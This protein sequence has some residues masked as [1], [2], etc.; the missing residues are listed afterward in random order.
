MSTAV[1]H[2]IG[3]GVSEKAELSSEARAALNSADVVIGSDRQLATVSL[4]DGV[5]THVLPKLAQ[6]KLDLDVM[7]SA[8]KSIALLASG[9]PLFYGIGGWLGKNF[10]AASLLFY[11]AVSS[12]QAACHR[13][14]ISLQDVDVVSLHGRPLSSIRRHLKPEATLVVLTDHKSNPRALAEECKAANFNAS[15]ITV[16]ET[17]G[18]KTEQVT[19]FALHELMQT[20]PDQ[21]DPLHVSIIQV[22]GVGGV[23]PV[24]PGF[25]DTL[26]TTGAAPGKGMISK[27]EARL[28]ILSYMQPNSG[29]VIWDIGAG[30]GGVAVELAYWGQR[31][32]IYAV[33]FHQERLQHLASNREKFG[34]VSN[35]NIVEGRAPDCLAEL[36]M[37]NKVFIGGSDGELE[38]LLKQTWDLLPEYGCLVASAVIEKTKNQLKGFVET[39]APHQVESVELAVKRGELAESAF[40]YQAKLPVEI[41]KF[42]KV[43]DAHG[44]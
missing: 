32:S 40:E 22:K 43:G 10:S 15:K 20:N 41:F 8:G 33:E 17:L 31:S 9:D 16:C 42:T 2:V 11:P 18:Y 29:D 30:C 19:R 12:I 5:Q 44:G 39:L 34:V 7:L 21:F 6:L 4:N 25:A 14:G 37:P 35:L 27:R 24:F 36:P 28:Q 23:L 3:L 1:I 38:H 13:I 26:F